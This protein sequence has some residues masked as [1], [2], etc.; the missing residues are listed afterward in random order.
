MGKKQET[1]KLLKKIES[2]KQKIIELEEMRP[3]SLSKQYNVCGTPNCKCKD[4]EKP[5]KHGPYYQLSYTHK[6][7]S[8][9]EFIRKQDLEITKKAIEDLK[10][11]I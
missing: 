7:R 5:Q 6:S 3:G 4:K 10:N 8:K 1:V 2:I 9:T 11:S